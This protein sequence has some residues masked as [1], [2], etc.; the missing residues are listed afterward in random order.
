MKPLRSLTLLASLLLVPAVLSADTLEWTDSTSFLRFQRPTEDMTALAPGGP[1]AGSA[2]SIFVEKSGIYEIESQQWVFED[3][4]YDGMLFL[5]A[6]S[7]D[8]ANPLENLVAADDDAEEPSTSRI[9]VLLTANVIYRVVTTTKTLPAGAPRFINRIT[10]PG[11][12][13]KSACFLDEPDQFDDG[14]ELALLD[15]RFCVSATWKD[16]QGNTGTARPVGHRT[17]SSGQFWFFSDENWELSFKMVDGCGLNERV[18]FFLSGTTN[19][20]WTV[21]VREIQ[22]PDH[23]KVYTNPLGRATRPVLDT[24]AFDCTP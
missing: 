12:I 20:E 1:V 11:E 22:A 13:H 15:G 5:Y 21:R 4:K 17:D 24:Q 18:W 10:G 19:V 9:S 16:F 7:F 8:P 23:E 6:E 3:D 2:L 14:T